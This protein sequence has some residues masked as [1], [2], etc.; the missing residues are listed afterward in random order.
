VSSNLTA[1]ASSF[2]ALDPLLEKRERP[3]RAA[4][5]QLDVGCERDRSFSGDYISQRGYAWLL[6]RLLCFFKPFRH[7]DRSRLIGKYV[8]VRDE[9]DIGFVITRSVDAPG[10]TPFLLIDVLVVS[11]THR[12]TGA[13][14]WLVRSIIERQPSGTVLG[15]YCSKF[16]RA[17]QRVLKNLR[18]RRQPE[19]GALEF[20]SF[21]KQ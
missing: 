12:G 1:S 17:M 19:S 8:L 20:Y 16:A 13:G 3:G 9:A 10:K 6:W 4:D 15:A 18:F 14:T 5:V 11:P 2:F 21:T 7:D